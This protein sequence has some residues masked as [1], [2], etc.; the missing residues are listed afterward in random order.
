KIEE[1]GYNTAEL[2]D[3]ELAEAEIAVT[4]GLLRFSGRIDAMAGLISN[5]D[6]F[7]GYDSCGQHVA[8]ATKT[9]AIICFTG[10]ANKR[11]LARWQPGNHHGKTT[12]FIIDQQT[13]SPKH[14]PGLNQK[15]AQRADR[16]RT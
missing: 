9:P 13:M 5:S 11:F 10:A 8:T 6:L 4:H 15:I 16:Y 14:S 2:S 1:K 3:Q 7:I 12:T